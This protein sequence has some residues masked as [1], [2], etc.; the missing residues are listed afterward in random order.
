MPGRPAGGRG[1]VIWP[2]SAKKPAALFSYW[3]NTSSGYNALEIGEDR[4]VKGI[5]KN[6]DLPPNT[7]VETYTGIS[8]VDLSQLDKVPGV[9]KFFD[10][11]CPFKT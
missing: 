2:A 6:A 3:V 7:Q 11:V 1:A 5:T 8:F 10:S 9:S 4:F